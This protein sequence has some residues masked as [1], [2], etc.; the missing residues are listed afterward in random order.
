LRDH[1]QVDVGGLRIAFWDFDGITEATPETQEAVKEAASALAKAGATVK[2][3]RPR[4]LN[5]TYDIVMSLL[6]PMVVEE[7]PELLKMHGAENDPEVTK[8]IRGCVEWMAK[9]PDRQSKA[10]RAEWLPYQTDWLKFMAEF[11]AILCPVNA[12]PAMKHDTTQENNA[13]F[14][15]TV[16]PSLVGSLPSGTVRCSTSPK[17]LPIGV[18]VIG[19]RWR[20]DI[21]LAV[22]DYLEKEFGGWKPPPEENLE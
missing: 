9:T 22:L 3:D 15:Y 19:A 8:I 6:S 10:F 2:C 21:V 5:K 7:M 1:K 20:E 13:S 4:M 16:A 12:F 17:G 14:C 18:Q 11:Q